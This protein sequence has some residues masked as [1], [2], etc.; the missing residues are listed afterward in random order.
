MHAAQGGS[1]LMYPAIGVEVHPNGRFFSPCS[2][3]QIYATLQTKGECF[4]QDPPCI[5]G[6]ACCLGRT[7][8]AQ[9]AS[10]F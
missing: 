9:V 1:Y 2:L 10:D 8:L 6:G 7:L 4:V 5:S 3:A